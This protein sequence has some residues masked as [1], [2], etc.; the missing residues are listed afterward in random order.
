MTACSLACLIDP[1]PD[2]PIYAPEWLEK[3]LRHNWPEYADFE[4][5]PERSYPP[6]RARKWSVGCVIDGEALIQTRPTVRDPSFRFIADFVRAPAY[7]TLAQYRV[8][9]NDPN[10][11]SSSAGRY[12]RWTSISR[13][14]TELESDQEQVKT[15]REHIRSRLPERLRRN[16]VQQSTE[17]I[18]LMGFLAEIQQLVAIRPSRIN[19]EV[20][21]LAMNK[22][23][24]LLREILGQD[25]GVDFW[26]SDGQIV[27]VLNHLGQIA[28][29]QGPP[30]P[31]PNSNKSSG[32][33][34]NKLDQQPSPYSLLL[35][36]FR[37]PSE[38]MITAPI[39]SISHRDPGRVHC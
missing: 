12:P 9:G 21:C 23:D 5:S 25:V 26:V 1:S 18:L 11:N 24:E 28:M 13:L 30:R 3:Q 37:E 8:L 14:A 20:C 34:S 29:T 16:L 33:S 35:T 27:C 19:P 7:C 36:T 2:R 6:V 31:P 32:N 39:F 17:E 38:E 15:L 4:P 22:F 10:Y